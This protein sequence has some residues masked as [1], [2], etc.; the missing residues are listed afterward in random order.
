MQTG[1]LWGQRWQPGEEEKQLIMEDR[2]QAQSHNCKI[3]HSEKKMHQAPEKMQERTS[4][5]WNVCL[6][7]EKP[8]Q[9]Q[10]SHSVNKSILYLLVLEEV[11]RHY[12]VRRELADH[13]SHL[14]ARVG[15]S[16]KVNLARRL[17]C[18]QRYMLHCAS[19]GVDVDLFHTDQGHLFQCC[20]FIPTQK[21]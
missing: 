11:S 17:K 21:I 2:P 8:L 6:Q 10:S 5:R 4:Q 15:L 1:E 20:L 9:E 12:D 7:K 13:H 16:C 18:C 3:T 14:H 19:A